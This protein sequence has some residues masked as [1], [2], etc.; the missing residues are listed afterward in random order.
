[1]FMIICLENSQPTSLVASN[2]MIEYRCVLTVQT[3][4]LSSISMFANI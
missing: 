2:A 4:E 3:T 1:M